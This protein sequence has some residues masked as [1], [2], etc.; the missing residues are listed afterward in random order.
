MKRL[1]QLSFALLLVLAAGRLFAQPIPGVTVLPPQL[2]SPSAFLSDWQSR[3]STATVIVNNTS[4]SPIQAK[5]WVEFFLNGDLTKPVAFSQPDKLPFST[6]GIGTNTFNGETLAPLSSM[7]FENSIDQSTQRAGRIPNG[8]ICIRINVLDPKT[9]RQSSSS[10]VCSTIISYFPPQLL[11]PANN[12]E[13]C[14]VGQNNVIFTKDGQPMPIFQWTPIAPAPPMVVKYHFAI[15]E[16]LP[17][18]EPIAAIRGNRAVFEQDVLGMNSLLWP[19]QF[20]LPE[21]GKYYIWS[22]RALDDGGLP[23]IQSNDGWAEPFKFFVNTNC[24]QASSLMDGSVSGAFDGMQVG[25]SLLVIDGATAATTNYAPSP[26]NP[27]N[28]ISLQCFPE[29]HSIYDWIRASFSM[30]YMRKSGEIKAAD[31]K[32]ETRHIREFKDALLTGITFPA[33]DGAA[34]DPAYLTL[35]FEPKVTRYHRDGGRVDE[36][37]EPAQKEWSPA[38]FRLQIDGIDCSRVNKVESITIKQKVVE[39]GIGTKRDST[40]RVRTLDVDNIVIYISEEYAHDFQKWFEDF[41]IAGNNDEAKHK[42]GSMVYLNR[43]RQKELLTLSLSG[44]GIFKISA[45]AQTN[46]DDKVKLVRIELSVRGA[47]LDPPGEDHSSLPSNASGKLVRIVHPSLDEVSLIF[48]DPPATTSVTAQFNPKEITIDKSVPWQKQRPAQGDSP[49]PEFTTGDPLGMDLELM[50]DLYEGDKT[51]LKKSLDSLSHYL[52]TDN[53][54]PTRVKVKWGTLP[55]FRGVLE[56]LN[57]KYTLF[58]EDGT[59]VR[60]TCT[61]RA[62]PIKPRLEGTP[63]PN[64]TPGQHS[65][66]PH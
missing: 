45:P 53:K 38:N 14:K 63:D 19:Q 55:E 36:P 18:Q 15:F 22:V 48:A 54:R 42:S 41:S 17:N 59:P 4:S 25:S 29:N 58:A 31:F 12:T 64:V 65:F 16:I 50:F 2:N 30:N 52:Q 28:E 46:N 24:D 8:Q 23:F 32:R 33:C 5:I 51:V 49:E 40:K 3:A 44:L 37:N 62:R 47:S 66:T 27:E 34:K 10:I 1:F 21:P 26:T 61:V 6:V 60:A 39:D 56:S 57:V 20:F 11:L 9:G 43:T 7:H 35:K 13:L